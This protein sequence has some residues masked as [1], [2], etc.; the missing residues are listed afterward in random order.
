MGLITDALVILAVSILVVMLHETSYEGAVGENE[1]F[2]FLEEDLRASWDG[3]K[4]AGAPKDTQ[5]GAPEPKPTQ[6]GAGAGE[7]H[8]DKDEAP[9]KHECAAC[10]EMVPTT[11]IARASCRHAYCRACLDAI[12]K[13]ALAGGTA[14]PPRCC[15][16]NIP[17]KASV[18][19][20]PAATVEAV[21]EKLE[22][23][24]TP[25]RTYCHRPLCAAFV[26]AHYQRDG[27]ALCPKC[28]A[29]TC[30]HCKGEAHGTVDCPRDEHLQ[31]FLDTARRNLWQRCPNCRIMVE[32]KDGCA[33]IE[34]VS[35]RL[36]G[37]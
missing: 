32:R 14:F 30:L 5:R 15:G 34:Y 36:R 13:T 23:D 17:L 27:E 21:F 8:D 22:L 24:A 31:Q 20:L 37:G 1:D 2:R 26:P 35:V 18:P 7:N 28:H 3:I 10:L 4:N 11:D 33:H 9:P 29:V 6:D 12:V 16:Q 19:L 25:D